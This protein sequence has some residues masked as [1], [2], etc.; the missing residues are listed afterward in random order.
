MDAQDKKMATDI[1]YE[2]IK[3]VSR[4]IRPYIGTPTQGSTSILIHRQ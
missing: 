3:E 4:A 1:A 2:I